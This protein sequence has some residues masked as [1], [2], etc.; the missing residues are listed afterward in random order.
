MPLMFRRPHD[1][2]LRAVLDP[3]VPATLLVVVRGGSSTGKTAPPTKP[4]SPGSELAAGLPAGPRRAMSGWMPGSQP[5]RSVAGRARQYADA[6]GGPAVLGRLADLL[7][8]DGHLVITTMWPEHWRRLYHCGAR[9]AQ[10]RNRPGPPG[11][12][13]SRCRN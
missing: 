4:S 10:S 9:R 12:C 2:L 13:S 11:G 1:E 7:Q 3:V 8:G 6:D 5:G